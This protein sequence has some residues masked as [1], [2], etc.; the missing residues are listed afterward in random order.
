M[1]TAASLSR[2]SQAI[3]RFTLTGRIGPDVHARGVLVRKARIYV[4]DYLQRPHT[5]HTGFD[6]LPS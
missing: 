5:G 3:C 1:T 2:E 4:L 6:V